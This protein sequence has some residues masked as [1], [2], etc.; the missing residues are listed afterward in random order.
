MTTQ[1]PNHVLGRVVDMALDVGGLTVTV[2]F[3]S[4]EHYEKTMKLWEDTNRAIAVALWE[5]E[6]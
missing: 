2:E 4:Q 6:S 5:E 1:V 3:P